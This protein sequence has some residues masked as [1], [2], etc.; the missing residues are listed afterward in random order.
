M[1]AHG[2]QIA[3]RPEQPKLR[4]AD[5]LDDPIAQIAEWLANA[6]EVASLPEAMTL[7]TIDESGDPDARMVLLRGVAADGLRFYTDYES[8][9]GHQLAAHPTAALVI[10]WRA[11]DRQLRARGPVR[12][13]SADDSDAYFQGR[14][15]VARLA[16]WISPQ[17]EPIA[18]REALEDRFREQ[19][20]R[21]DGI[22]V[23]RPPFWGG[24]VLEPH[25]IEFFQSQRSRL[26]D[27][28]LYTRSGE[29]WRVER[30]AP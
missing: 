17:S 29:R 25:T 1:N 10:Y 21:F 27:R 23:S 24:Y 14:P 2:E 16:A 26:H 13:A 11:L 6:R 30:L 7:A 22:D 9:K 28:F 4:R 3:G 19:E 20:S 15:R 18:S 12:R 5:L 8:A